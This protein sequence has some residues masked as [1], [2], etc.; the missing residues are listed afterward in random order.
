MEKNLKVFQ[1]KTK[2]YYNALTKNNSYFQK[3]YSMWVLNANGEII[4]TMENI[5]RKALKKTPI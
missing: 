4:N 2:A 1:K 5:I 3:F